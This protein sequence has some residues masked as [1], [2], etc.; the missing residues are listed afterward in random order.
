MRGANGVCHPARSEGAVVSRTNKN[1]I[2]APLKMTAR[3]TAFR[4]PDAGVFRTTTPLWLLVLPCGTL[5]YVPASVSNALALPATSQSAF[6]RWRKWQGFALFLAALSRTA[7]PSRKSETS[8]RRSW[9]PEIVLDSTC[10]AIQKK[11][12]S[13]SNR[14]LG[15]ARHSPEFPAQLR[16]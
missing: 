16:F 15:E 13:P 11:R 7:Q 2:L 6:P 1:Q 14:R 12:P 8:R 9:A 3:W 10:R 5:R 4:L